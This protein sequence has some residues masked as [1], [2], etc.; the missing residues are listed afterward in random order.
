MSPI[1]VLDLGEFKSVACACGP[2]TTAARFATVAT[3]PD[4]LR[5]FPEAERP[6]LVVFE[7]SNRR[8]GP[9]AIR[10]RCRV[11]RPRPRGVRRRD[12]VDVQIIA[13]TTKRL[14]SRQSSADPARREEPSQD[15]K[16]PRRAGS[17]TATG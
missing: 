1:I 11:D 9:K 15:R 2:E 16:P 8:M 17:A 12:I 4:G 3:D 7:T 10:S 6:A 5:E 13:L 14:P